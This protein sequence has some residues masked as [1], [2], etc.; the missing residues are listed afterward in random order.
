MPWD[1]IIVFYLAGAV[2]GLGLFKGSFQ[3][4]DWHYSLPY[5]YVAFFGSWIS[6]WTTI[7]TVLRKKGC[8]GFELF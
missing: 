5:C 1:W 3:K 2:M 8:F 4:N 7:D 6:V